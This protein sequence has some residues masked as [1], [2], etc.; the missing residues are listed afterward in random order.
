MERIQKILARAGMASRRSCE[1]LIEQGR[2][3]VNGHIA[4]LG[5]RADPAR[6]T[7]RVDGRLVELAPASVWVVLNKPPG[8]VVS[9]RAQGRRKTAREL[10]ALPG[11]LFAVG[12]LDVES[13]GLVLLTNDG[14]LAEHLSHPRYEHE[15]EYRIL[16]NRP[17]EEEQ[18]ER[19][20]R[21]LMLA[22]GYRTRP[23]RVWRERGGRTNRWL[24][25][26]LREGHKR[27]IRESARAVGLRVERLIRV[28]LGPF[29]LGT[30]GPG[31]WRLASPGELEQISPSPRAPA[32]R[33]RDPRLQRARGRPVASARV[34]ES[35]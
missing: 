29:H 12:R 28:R 33:R 31:E 24:R 27:Q 18:I 2:V 35:A 26:V 4:Q 14:D 7:I 19:W 23:A 20:S 13:E 22:D 16:L 11:R 3:S 34:K 30:M 6:D 32:G 8:V 17:P 5:E 9:D 25:L 15:K 21:G 1:A 10:V